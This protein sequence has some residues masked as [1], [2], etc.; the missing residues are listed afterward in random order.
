MGRGGRSEGF[1]GK[2]DYRL[3]KSV[4]MI[5]FTTMEWGTGGEK[6]YSSFPWSREG[7]PVGNVRVGRD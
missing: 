1:T 3:G 5:N 2:Y 6:Q 4:S 7:G